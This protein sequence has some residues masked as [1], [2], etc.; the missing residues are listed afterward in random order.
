[1]FGKVVGAIVIQVLIAVADV[2]AALFAIGALFLVL[3]V[4]SRRGL[5]SADTY[6]DVPVVAMS[7]LRRIPEFAP[8]P[9]AALE[10]VARETV[11]P[12]T[13]TGAR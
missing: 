13:F 9:T 2:E 8:L 7:L 10:A 1:M 4:A 6:A 11:E 12:A 5:R 3:L